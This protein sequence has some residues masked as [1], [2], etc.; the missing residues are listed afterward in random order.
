MTELIR[1]IYTAAVY[2]VWFLTVE[3]TVI[4]KYCFKI[5]LLSASVDSGVAGPLVAWCG[6][7]ICRLFV[8]I[9]H[10]HV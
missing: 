2:N 8:F 5:V 3:T 9:L 4:C 1:P 7:Q 6:G 10:V